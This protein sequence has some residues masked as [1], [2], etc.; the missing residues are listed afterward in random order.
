MLSLPTGLVEVADGIL[1]AA[2]FLQAAVERYYRVPVGERS[3]PV[4]EQE[5]HLPSDF[6]DSISESQLLSA[7]RPSLLKEKNATPGEGAVSV[8]SCFEE[9]RPS[10]VVPETSGQACST[11]AKL[12]TSTI[13]SFGA[14]SQSSD[15]NEP[16]P[17]AANIEEGRLVVQTGHKLLP[18]WEGKYFSTILPFVIPYMVSG[19]DFTFADVQK[20]WRRGAVAPGWRSTRTARGCSAAWQTCTATRGI[21]GAPAP[22]CGA[23]SPSGR[24]S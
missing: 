3:R 2:L 16:P 9:R 21:R 23:W 15:P 13:C 8:E 22:T 20:R 19:P 5:W 6:F 17:Q 10:S 14:V 1:D 12:R 24:T 4:E 18:Q 11:P 7:K